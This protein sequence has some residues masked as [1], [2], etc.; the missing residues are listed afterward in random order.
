MTEKKLGKSDSL[1]HFLSTE[2]GNVV[3]YIKWPI[4]VMSFDLVRTIVLGVVAADK[5][6]TRLIARILI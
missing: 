4:T 1:F 3:N 6:P 5:R 2:H